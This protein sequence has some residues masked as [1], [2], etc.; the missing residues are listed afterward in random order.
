MSEVEPARAEFLG[1][2]VTNLRENL[3]LQIR[4][5]SGLRSLYGALNLFSSTI[6]S[7]GNL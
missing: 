7:V 2:E 6:R 1:R 3:H 5:D 4:W